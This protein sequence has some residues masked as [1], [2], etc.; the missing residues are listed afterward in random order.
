MIVFPQL[1]SKI[2]N[3]LDK[4]GR[5]KDNASPE[6]SK[7]RRE[8]AHISGGISKSLNAILRM[9][10]NEGLVEKRRD[11]DNARRKAGYTCRSRL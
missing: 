5:I 11:S 1:I 9:A 7:I 4:F 6:L 3:I 10:Q 2:D 8:I